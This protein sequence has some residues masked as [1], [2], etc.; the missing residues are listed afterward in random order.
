[1]SAGVVAVLEFGGIMRGCGDD[2]SI[3]QVG[4]QNTHANCAE[5]TC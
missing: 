5:L 1:M 2:N 3:I 4:R